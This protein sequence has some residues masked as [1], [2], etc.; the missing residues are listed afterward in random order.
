[1]NQI[2]AGFIA[3]VFNGAVYAQT[4][5]ISVALNKTTSLVFPQMI[6]AVDKGSRDVL[7]QK[8]PDVENVLQVKAGK[9]N[10]AETN[11]TVITTNGRLY[12]FII[13]YAAEPARLHIEIDSSVSI[14]EKIAIKDKSVHGVRDKNY[15][16][17]L[18]LKG[19]YIDKDILYYQLEV[20]NLSNISYDIDMLHFYI[21][22]RKQSRRTASQELQQVPLY[23]FGNTSSVMGQS[24]Q[25]IVVALPKFTIPDKKI[26]YVSVLEKNGGRHLQLKIRNKTIVKASLLAG[27]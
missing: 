23:V 1:M 2:I 6:K 7:T 9:E 20:E 4:D 21:K 10:F 14:F 11:M 5:T 12:S 27:I 26:F 25:I 3:L 17:R 22:D 19:L 18:C 16:M 13:R 8:V 15:D 24:K